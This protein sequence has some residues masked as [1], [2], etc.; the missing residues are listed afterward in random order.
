MILKKILLL[1]SKVLVT[2]NINYIF[3]VPDKENMDILGEDNIQSY[4]LI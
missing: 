3:L 1:E 2:G 4:C